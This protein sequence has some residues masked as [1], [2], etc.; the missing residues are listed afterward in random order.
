MGTKT[1]TLFERYQKVFKKKIERSLLNQ[2]SDSHLMSKKTVLDGILAL[3]LIR[4][5]GVEV[6]GAEFFIKNPKQ[7]K[8][9]IEHAKALWKLLKSHEITATHL[10]EDFLKTLDQ[11]SQG[12]VKPGLALGASK[13]LINI[14][15]PKAA[16]EIFIRELSILYM[17]YFMHSNGTA[18]HRPH[19]EVIF[20][21]AQLIDPDIDRR[22]VDHHL[23]RQQSQSALIDA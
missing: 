10:S 17:E 22:V 9:L 4:Y 15:H 18:L 23:S 12:F 2:Y 3:A 7:D 1:S 6:F 5:V 14:N 13:T 19:V 16:R 20:E 11:L 21:M 8:A